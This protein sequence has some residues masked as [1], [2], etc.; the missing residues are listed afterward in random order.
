LTKCPAT[1]VILNG[2]SALL[3]NPN[4][5]ST[6][7]PE[8]IFLSGNFGKT[9]AVWAKGEGIRIIFFSSSSSSSSSSSF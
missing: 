9:T 2:L 6:R 8:G 5:T 4:K 1:C 7:S 3:T